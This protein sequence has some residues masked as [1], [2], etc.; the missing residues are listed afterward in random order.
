MWRGGPVRMVR[1]LL[2]TLLLGW[3]LL[4]LWPGHAQTLALREYTIA[5]GLPQSVVY[6]ICQDS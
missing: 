6:A 1:R 2:R 5:N 4:G 3:G